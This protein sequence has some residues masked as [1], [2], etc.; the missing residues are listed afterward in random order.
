[1]NKKIKIAAVAFAVIFAVICIIGVFITS[2]DKIQPNVSINGI[3]VGKL[4]VFQ[5]RL[6]I[7]NTIDTDPNYTLNLI[8]ENNRWQL[9]YKDIKFLFKYEEAVDEAYAIGHKGFFFKKMYEVVKSNYIK[10]DI[11]TVTSFD[12]KVIANKVTEIAKQLNHEPQDA[13]IRL[14]MEDGFIINDEIK[15]VT[16]KESEAIQKITDVVLKM[17]VADIILPV[18]LK[19]AGIK[20]SDLSIITDELG[21]YSTRFNAADVARTSNIKI[22]T[23]SVTDVLV[24]PGE[25]FSLNKTVGPRLAKN[26]YQLAHVIVNNQ[27]VDGIG[28]G[29]CQVSSTLY[30]AALLSNMTIVERRNHSLPSTYVPL[31]RDAT[32]SGDFIDFKFKNTTNYPIY[33]YGEVVGSWVK[34][35]IYGKNDFPNRSVTIRSDVITKTEAKT[36]IVEDPTLPVGTEKEERKAYTGYVVKTYRTIYENGKQIAVEPPSTSVYKV[37]NGLKKIGTKKPD[38]ESPVLDEAGVGGIQ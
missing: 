22:A 16:L 37:V 35:S 31:G 38:I 14:S 30:N 21:E 13:T 20:R 11:K 5:A 3:D 24:Q 4:T 23:K 36:D 17:N 18:T 26:G 15:G 9:S 32:I 33:I 25:V 19:D 7:L 1:M 10:T 34:F 28:G 12:K 27:L 6:K 29:V 2:G 8:Y